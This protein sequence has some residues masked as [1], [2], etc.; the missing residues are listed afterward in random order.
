MRC[1]RAPGW[2][3]DN[4]GLFG[5]PPVTVVVGEEVHATLR[6]VARPAGA[7]AARGPSTLPVDGQG[8]MRADALPQL[9]GPA[10]VCI[11]AGNVNTGAFDPA[12]EL[13]DWAHDAGA[14]GCTWTARLGSGRA[15]RRRGPQLV[16]GYE[17]AD[18]W[19]TDAHKWLN[20]PYDCGIAMVR[21]AGRARARPWR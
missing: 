21:D 4:D 19:A 12:P 11:Q 18:S 3:V 8:R 10:I 2:D 9:R 16:E 6:R 1:W 15:P 17:L 7:G 5:A 13:C 20:V 14:P